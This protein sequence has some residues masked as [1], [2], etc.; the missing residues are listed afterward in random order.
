[1]RLSAFR[2]TTYRYIIR[3]NREQEKQSGP[4]GEQK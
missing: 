1:M 4:A 2:H 3:K